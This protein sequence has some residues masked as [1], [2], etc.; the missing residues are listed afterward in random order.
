ML[1]MALEKILGDKFSASDLTK[2]GVIA[3]SFNSIKLDL[4][5]SPEE[6]KANLKAFEDFSKENDTSLYS[7]NVEFSENAALLKVGQNQF[8]G[9][10]ADYISK[11]LNK[12]FDYVGKQ[13]DALLAP[14]AIGFVPNFK[15]D[16][17]TFESSRAIVAKHSLDQS[18]LSQLDKL[19]KGIKTSNDR[20]VYQAG[21]TDYLSGRDDLS[22]FAKQAILSDDKGIYINARINADYSSILYEMGKYGGITKFAKSVAKAYSGFTKEMSD[23]AE[24]KMSDLVSKKAQDLYNRDGSLKAG[25]YAEVMKAMDDSED[26]QK[27]ASIVDNFKTKMKMPGSLV[28]PTLKSAAVYD[29]KAKEAAKAKAS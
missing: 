10:I 12:V 25:H 14:F 26:Y 27:Y 3:N 16:N 22:D 1:S 28:D 13:D 20:T 7:E 24:G 9:N 19:R 4:N 21:L 23:E 18:T 17:K 8:N 5:Q 15:S 11:N 6:Q 2:A 29:A